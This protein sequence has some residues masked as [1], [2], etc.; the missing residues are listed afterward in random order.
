[1]AGAEP[2]PDQVDEPEDGPPRFATVFEA[3]EWG[4]QTPRP[5]GENALL[6]MP[7]LDTVS[8]YYLWRHRDHDGP[9]RSAADTV[10]A[11]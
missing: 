11:A 5:V 2:E 7:G 3:L 9:E 4:E 8:E 6:A 10:G 1:V